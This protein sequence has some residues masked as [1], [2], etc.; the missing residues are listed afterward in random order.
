MSPLMSITRVCSETLRTSNVVAASGIVV[1][2]GAA[3]GAL[4][5]VRDGHEVGQ[6]GDLEDLA[7][8]VRQS[9][10]LHLDTVRAG[11]GEEPDDQRNTGAVYVV[12]VLEVEDDRAG[13]TARGL[14]IGDVQR[15][16]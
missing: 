15:V 5:V 14:C 2:L 16:L 3:H 10:C 4:F 11:L 6:P 13:A 12:G 9:E 7:V 8:V 1:P